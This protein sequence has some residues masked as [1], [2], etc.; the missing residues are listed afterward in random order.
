MYMHINLSSV[1]YAK[2]KE[3]R[4]H[5]GMLLGQLAPIDRYKGYSTNIQHRQTSEP[6]QT[7]RQT[8]RQTD[9][10]RQTDGQMVDRADYDSICLFPSGPTYLSMWWVKPPTLRTFFPGWLP[11]PTSNV[12]Q[13]ELVHSIF[14]QRRHNMTALLI[15][16]LTTWLGHLARREGESEERTWDKKDMCCITDL[17]Q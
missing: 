7:Y 9:W 4:L 12:Q 10:L 11:S 14:P 17:C 5:Y 8:D 1:S 6:I 15:S 3:C 16:S 2:I 13:W